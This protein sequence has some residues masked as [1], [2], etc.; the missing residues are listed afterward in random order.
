MVLRSDLKPP[1]GIAEIPGGIKVFFVFPIREVE[2]EVLKVKA[3]FESNQFFNRVNEKK[4]TGDSSENSH[5]NK[6]FN[7]NK[8]DDASVEVTDDKVKEA[9]GAF[10]AD[11]QARVNGLTA[12]KI[13]SGP[14]LKVILKDGTG[15]IIRQMTGEEFIRLREIVSEEG[16][17]RGKILD[18]KL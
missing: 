10:A 6:D 15:R 11:S 8:K 12:D 14:G 17:S 13:G 5:K 16:P 4:D 2:D 18:Q 3:L 9:L 1:P 7:Q